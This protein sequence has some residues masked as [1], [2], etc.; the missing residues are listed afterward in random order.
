MRNS[1]GV[2]HISSEFSGLKPENHLTRDMGMSDPVKPSITAGQNVIAKIGGK[3]VG[4][5][6]LV[7]IA[8]GKATLQGAETHVVPI[9]DVIRPA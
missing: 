7:Q 6:Y 5:I 2:F 3:E 9:A 8:E 1:G 4:P